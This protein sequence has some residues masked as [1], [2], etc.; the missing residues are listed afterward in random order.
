M[1]IRCLI[2]VEY[3]KIEKRSFNQENRNH[4]SMFF[5]KFDVGNWLDSKKKLKVQAGNV[6]Q[7]RD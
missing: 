6:R 1:K 7:P 2:T 3:K 5:K 4:P